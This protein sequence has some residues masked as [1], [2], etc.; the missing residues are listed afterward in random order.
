M[1]RLFILLTAACL[2]TAASQA[3]DVAELVRRGE[4][5]FAETCSSGYCH[6]AR[7]V[8]GGA[9]RLAARGFTEQFINNTVRNGVPGTGMPTFEGNLDAAGLTAVI[10]YVASLNG[11]ASASGAGATGASTEARAPLSTNAQRG[12]ALFSDA[13]RGFGRCST[14]HLV[15]RLGIPVATPIY[16]V[17]ATAAALKALTAPN[18]KTVTVGGD[19]MPAL[20]VAQKADEVQFYDL[21][22]AAPVLRTEAPANV[23]ITDGGT[24]RHA[25]VIGDYS[26]A[27]LGTILQY[28]NEVAG[29]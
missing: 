17:P 18:V 22:S 5:Q 9:P 8:G 12:E 20:V 27:E 26:D 13:V 4:S 11:V 14:C 23:R 16:D 6:G 24:W 25:S 15:G 10:A 29:E 7:G 2:V 21:T 1:K 19:A 3:Q 28:L